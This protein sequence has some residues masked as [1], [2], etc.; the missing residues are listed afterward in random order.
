LAFKANTDDIRY[1]PAIKTISQLLESGATVRA[2]DPV[3][4]DNMKKIFPQIFYTCTPYEAI[5][6]A[7][8]CIIMTEWPEFKAL[9]FER[10][11]L[12]MKQKIIVDMRGIIDREKLCSLGFHVDIIGI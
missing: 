5:E 10:I 2:Y 11:A 4:A 7:D 9:E 12:A 1:S 8:A 3:A 6:G